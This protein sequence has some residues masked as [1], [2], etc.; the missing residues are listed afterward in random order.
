MV[1]LG[2]DDDPSPSFTQR[3]QLSDS[4]NYKSKILTLSSLHVQTLICYY[5]N[6]NQRIRAGLKQKIMLASVRDRVRHLIRS[7]RVPFPRAREEQASL[8]RTKGATT[9]YEC[10]GASREKRMGVS[11]GMGTLNSKL[12]HPLR[13][14]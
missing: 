1:R 13:L 11:T 8:G 6:A 14:L 10:E 12:Q 2:R 4:L 9:R 3:M 5:H 7:N